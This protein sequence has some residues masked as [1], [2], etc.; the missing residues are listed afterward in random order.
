[1]KRTLVLSFICLLLLLSFAACPADGNC[2]LV[3]HTDTSVPFTQIVDPEASEAFA[4]PAAPEKRGH[5]F[6]GWYLDKECTKPFDTNAIVGNATV[7]LYACYA[8]NAYTVTMIVGDEEEVYTVPFGDEIPLPT[9]SS[10]LLAFDGFYTDADFTE[11]LTDTKMP[12][13]NITLYVRWKQKPAF[14]VTVTF[15]ANETASTTETIPSASLDN[16]DWPTPAKAG[17]RFTGWYLDAACTRPFDPTT[18]D[19]ECVLDLYAGYERNS[20]TVTLFDGT[21]TERYT[22]LFGDELIL[23]EPSSDQF[24]FAGFYLD[25]AFTQPLTHTTM[26]ATDLAVYVKWKNAPGTTVTFFL[27]EGS[28]SPSMLL[29]TIEELAGYQWPTPEKEGHR[30][31]GWYLDRSCTVPFDPREMANV[32]TLDLY[33]DYAVN[34]YTLTVHDG[35][36]TTVYTFT[37]GEAIRLEEPS[38][39]YFSFGGFYM[40]R[41]CI[42]ELPYQTMPGRDLDVYV[43][44]ALG[45]TVTI[46]GSV[47]GAL[48]F[49]TGSNV[50]VKNETSQMI[51]RASQFKPVTVIASTGYRFVGYEV[52]GVF[53]E[54][55]TITLPLSELTKDIVIRAIADYATYELPIIN[56]TTKNGVEIASKTDYTDM[57][58]SL[59]NA[60]EELRAIAGGIRLRGNTTMTYPKKPYRI[61]FDKKQSLFG[62]EKAKSWVLLAEYLDPSAL[63]NYTALSIGQMADG[64]KFNATAHKVNVY[65]NGQFDGLYTLCEQ[66]QEDEGRIDIEKT[67][68]PDMTDLF[69][70]NFFFC[71]DESVKSDAFAVEGVNYFVI[72]KYGTPMYFEL[73][74]PEKEDFTSEA[75]FRSFFSQLSS[76]VEDMLDI[77]YTRNYARMQQEY[78]LDSLIDYFIIDQ[79][80]G[81]HDHAKKSFNMYYTSTSSDPRENC[82]LTFG[83]IWDYD[84]SLNT[85]W[86]NNPNVYYDLE[87]AVQDRV[88]SNYFFSAVRHIPDLYTR[89]R[90]RY[91]D[92]F[93]PALK[94]LLPELYQLQA[95][96]KESLALNQQRWYTSNPSITRDNINFLNRY[97]EGKIEHLKEKWKIS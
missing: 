44:W 31:L 3:F 46:K 5:T 50:A 71:L 47:T 70:Y 11:K 30:F 60:D 21:G 56:I 74:Y 69:D 82:R 13:S 35:G 95:D 65:V 76:Y 96:M 72:R 20:Y 23:P 89:A 25:A 53:Y 85:P 87:A 10:S 77:A 54:G 9:P 80:M 78:N 88:Y 26:P 83:P 79:I 17:F 43:D 86:T 68:T 4:P 40:E 18:L 38:S 41:A 90:I 67:I 14:N 33:A 45:Y 48:H 7:D 52:N 16:Y 22:F 49:K 63:H 51:V 19:G 75:Q 15:H 59:T 92:H 61:K 37:Y 24:V 97:L 64:M 58:F 28:A 2:T 29:L 27:H 6:L 62:L 91:Q 32:S 36:K 34:D 42:N 57:T 39:D 66:I 73:K 94:N 8:R 84:W 1:M 81:E 93:Y 55:N 12:D